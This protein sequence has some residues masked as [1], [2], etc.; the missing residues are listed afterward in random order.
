MSAASA[1]TA[2]RCSDTCLLTRVC[3]RVG[4]RVCVSYDPLPSYTWE[5]PLG[6]KTRCDWLTNTRRRVAAPVRSFILSFTPSFVP[7]IHPPAIF[8]IQPLIKCLSSMPFVWV[9]CFSSIRPSCCTD[10]FFFF[11]SCPPCCFWPCWWNLVIYFPL[12]NDFFRFF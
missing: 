4:V 6:L 12:S 5:P 8:Q 7:L 9:L 3:V 1:D 11:F 10:N 2:S